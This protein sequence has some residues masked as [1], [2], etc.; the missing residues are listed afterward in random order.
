MITETLIHIN[1]ALS[2]QQ[3]NQLLQSLG[4]RRGGMEAHHHSDKGHLLF[5]AYDDEECCP[6]DVVEMVKEQGL[7]AQLIDL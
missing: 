3:R 1:E 7:H 2:S 6:H 4:N 5:I